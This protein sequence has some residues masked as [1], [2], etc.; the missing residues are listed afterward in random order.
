VLDRHFR[1]PWEILQLTS[2][3]CAFG[4]LVSLRLTSLAFLGE[5]NGEL[6]RRTSVRGA[7]YC[8][9]KDSCYIFTVNLVFVVA[10][11]S[12]AMG[13]VA[14]LGA[15]TEKRITR[16]M[17]LALRRGATIDIT[18]RPSRLTS[19]S[20]VGPSAADVPRIKLTTFE[21]NCLGGPFVR[22]FYDCEDFA[23]ITFRGKRCTT[24]EALLLTGISSLGTTCTKPTRSC[25]CCLHASCRGKSFARSTSS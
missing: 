22:L 14:N 17:Q 20:K 8:G 23:Y 18:P 3:I 6:L 1:I 4:A 7:K 2:T 21:E 25:C 9:L 16:K 12:L 5:L 13:F 24:V 15:L 11:V 10:A 19:S